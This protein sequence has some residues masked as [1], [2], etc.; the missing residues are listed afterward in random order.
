MSFEEFLD[1]LATAEHSVGSVEPG[2][3]DY[4]VTVTG[5]NPQPAVTA[6][7]DFN[8]A[9]DKES[10]AMGLSDAEARAD[11]ELAAKGP[12]FES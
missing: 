11:G 5:V 10:L 1:K 3:V 4:K 8:A 7:S 6:G 9:A 2:Q 12:T